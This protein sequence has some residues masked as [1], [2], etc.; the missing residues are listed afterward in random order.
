MNIPSDIFWLLEAFL[1]VAFGMALA[2]R[3]RGRWEIGK[4]RRPEESNLSA[5]RLK[6]R[7]KDLRVAQQASELAKVESIVAALL[8]TEPA[9]KD[10]FDYF[11]KKLLVAI[12][13]AIKRHD[14]YEEQRSR[15]FQTSL[16]LMTGIL[17]IV[18]LVVRS[19]SSPAI[20]ARVCLWILGIITI[21]AALRAVLLYDMELDRDQPYRL[22]ADIRF[23]Y[24]RYSLPSASSTSSDGDQAE[25][26]AQHVATER[27]RFVDR[28]LA[29]AALP[30]SLREDMEQ[31]FVL[32]T[33]ARSKSESL[34]AMRWTLS[35]YVIFA[36]PQ[37]ILLG[38]AHG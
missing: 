3:P 14:W 33:L 13:Y 1:I 8:P 20:Q 32:H 6:G 36:V 25:D 27:T 35:Y 37:V 12:D 16:T 28:L 24:F 15:L 17:T 21:V 7:L 23:W 26:A 30:E 18:A 10:A 19:G 31:L 4:L 29:N 38:L 11:T 2:K 34:S 5:D 9:A 22:I